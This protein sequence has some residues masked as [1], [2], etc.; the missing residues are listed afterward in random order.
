MKNPDPHNTHGILI[1]RVVQEAKTYAQHVA[2]TTGGKPKTAEVGLVNAV[3]ALTTW[4]RS[5]G[6]TDKW[7]TD[8]GRETA[9]EPAVVSSTML[10]AAERP[11]PG[12][13]PPPP[14]TDP[15]TF[16]EDKPPPPDT[17]AAFDWE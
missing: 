10:A 15:F 7:R 13:A 4:E 8:G 12:P 16:T 1:L 6:N 3:G 2:I 9:P 11:A 17:S 5:R 14:D